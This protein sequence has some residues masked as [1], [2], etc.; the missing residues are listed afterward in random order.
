MFRRFFK[1]VTGRKIALVPAVAPMIGEDDTDLQEQLEL[2]EIELSGA[3]S[4]LLVETAES[5]RLAAELRIAKTAIILLTDG[6]RPSP[7]EELQANAFMDRVINES[8]AKTNKAKS[9]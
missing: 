3:Q 5:D 7:E 4:A 1:A 8:L 9:A 2:A 6:P